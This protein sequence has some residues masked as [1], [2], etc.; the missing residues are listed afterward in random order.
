MVKL[1]V[2][3]CI[4]GRTDPLHEPMNPGSTRFVMFT[5]QPIKSKHW[6]I[7]RV[8]K[9][10]RPKRECRKYKQPSHRIFPDAEVTLW[11]DASFT[12]RADPLDILAAHPQEFV[13][14]KHHKRQRITD[15][16]DAIIKAGK[17]KRD[18]ILAQ[19]AAYK[20]DGWDTDA[21]KQRAITNGGFML[22]RHTE[23]VIRFNE[24]WN[25]EVQARTLRD[26]MSLDY[27]AHKVGMP[28]AYFDGDVKRNDFATIHH[29]KNPTNDY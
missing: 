5:D 4:F 9:M 12:L 25:A 29:A 6:E 13:G 24:L 15:E 27:C 28:I 14:F 8:P 26:Q 19:L 18:E 21:N 10:D 7:V 3:S 1:V 2:Y 23:R 22:R 11:V 20:A 17:G 16:A